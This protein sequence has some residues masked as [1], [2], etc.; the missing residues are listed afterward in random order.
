MR[1]SLSAIAAILLI[2]GHFQLETA[3]IAERL[4]LSGIYVHPFIRSSYHWYDD[5]GVNLL[6][7]IK[8]V[9]DDILWIITYLILTLVARK[10]SYRLFLVCS[11]FLGYHIFDHFMLW[12]DYRSSHWLYWL[13]LLTDGICLLLFFIIK[14][15]KTGTIKSII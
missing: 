4:W 8:Y 7:W 15:K 14:D 11:V 10:Y 2:I 6:W 5:K 12:Y 13:E 3:E 1:K 9:C